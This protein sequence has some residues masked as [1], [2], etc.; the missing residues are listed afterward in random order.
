MRARY[1]KLDFRHVGRAALVAFAV[2][3]LMTPKPAVGAQAIGTISVGVR[4]VA[5]PA[6][7]KPMAAPRPG[8]TTSTT[9]VGTTTGGTAGETTTAPQG[10]R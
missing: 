3:A 7:S 10:G 4:I 1:L 9:G 2:V 6:N 8:N 5:T